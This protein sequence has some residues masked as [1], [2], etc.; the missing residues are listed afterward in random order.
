MISSQ[1]QKLQRPKN[2]NNENLPLD[3]I[4]VDDFVS[5]LSFYEERTLSGVISV[6]K[7]TDLPKGYVSLSLSSLMKLLCRLHALPKR[8]LPMRISFSE[9]GSALSVSLT[10]A[11]DTLSPGGARKIIEEGRRAGFRILYDGASFLTHL[12]LI[13]ETAQVYAPLTAFESFTDII[14]KIL[15]KHKIFKQ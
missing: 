6:D 13:K 15:K 1:R 3:H 11:C 4:S 2:K 14:E 10:P 8:L 5:G 7:P 12:S 9:E